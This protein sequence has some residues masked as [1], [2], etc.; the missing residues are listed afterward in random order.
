IGVGL[1]GPPVARSQQSA[2]VWL[3][4][5]ASGA[6]K[7][8]SAVPDFALVGGADPQN[9][10]K[11]LAEVTGG[12]LTFSALF[13]VVSGQPALPT[14]TD[15]LKPRLQEFAAAGA[16]EALQGILSVRSDRLEGEMRLYDLT[17]PDFRLIGT[18]K[19]QVHPTEPRRLAHKI[20]DEV[21]LLVTGEAGV[22][23]AKIAYTSTRSGVNDLRVMD[24]D[25]QAATPVTIDTEPTWSPTGREI[26]FVSDRSGAAQIYVMDDQGTNVR[27]IT[28]SGF[29]TQPRW[30]PKGDTIVFTSRQGNHD[31]WAVSPDG[32][33]LR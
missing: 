28:S 21:V 25:G 33:N 14:T 31:L 29:N 32:S 9:W 12:D 5:I 3:N 2:D 26:A 27:R 22:A 6:K 24:Y 15:G 18:K 10:A 20:A 7:V 8:N 30:S 17:S 13:S 4:V 16:H 11:R 23:D 1:A 19:I